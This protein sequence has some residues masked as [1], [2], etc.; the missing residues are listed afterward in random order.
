MNVQ[1]L[2]LSAQESWLTGIVCINFL[3]L[4]EANYNVDVRMCNGRGRSFLICDCETEIQL[5]FVMKIV[6]RRRRASSRGG[7]SAHMMKCEAEQC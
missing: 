5:D 6:R 1:K 7:V 2:S 3:S 4:G